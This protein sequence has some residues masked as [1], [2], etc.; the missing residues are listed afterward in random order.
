MNNH[1]TDLLTFSKNQAGKAL[2]LDEK[3]FR[4]GDIAAQIRAIFNHQATAKGVNL[5]VAYVGPGSG[6]EDTQGESKPGFESMKETIV[7]GDLFRILQVVIN[8]V[9][10]SLKF[11]PEGGSISLHIRQLQEITVLTP[12][13]S[14]TSSV[15]E[16]SWSKY[17]NELPSEDDIET[18]ST[19]PSFSCL[20]GFEF[21]VT[22]TGPGIQ[23]SLQEQIFKP[24]VQ[25]DAGLARKHGGTGLGLSICS[26]LAELMNGKIT[27]ESEVGRGSKFTLQVPLNVISEGRRNLKRQASVVTRDGSSTIESVLE[28]D[29]IAPELFVQ[30]GMH[31]PGQ[32]SAS[33]ATASAG[34]SSPSKTRLIGLTQPYFSSA[35]PPLTPGEETVPELTSKGKQ[36][37][38]VLVAEDNAV[39]QQVVLRMLRLEDIV[40][41]QIA[42]DGQEA[43][44]RVIESMAA[45]TP[46]DLVLMDVQMPRLDGRQSTKLIRQAGFTAPVI[47]LTA[48]ADEKNEKDCMEA[49]M[50]FFLEKP[51]KRDKLK[52]V[53]RR[54][55]MDT[56]SIMSGV[57]GGTDKPVG[58]YFGSSA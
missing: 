36:H 25:G 9:G 19:P 26:Q 5:R 17:A 23:K 20:V 37:L 21:E 30:T 41:V 38:K 15:H 24:F 56:G 3:R 4:L 32:R 45:K 7:W 12:C 8:L 39:N 58:S 31:L 10:N 46:Y 55:G 28:H 35:T 51:I 44:E 13:V 6:R 29:Q 52:R 53:L 16:D 34:N 47:A 43:L 1:L 54:Y 50:D 57:S 14:I 33:L 2:Q 49:G 11:T 40:D 22:D 18:E 42:K 48:F 27:L